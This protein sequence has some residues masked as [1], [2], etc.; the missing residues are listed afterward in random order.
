M[1]ISPCATCGYD[2]PLEAC[3][4]CS[5]RPEESI[6]GEPEANLGKRIGVGLAALP[7]G[8]G[9]LLVTG[10]VKRFLIP[11]VVLTSL[12]FAFLFFHAW[13]L[14]QEV[15]DAANLNDP[16][17]LYL[18]EGW[19]RDAAVWLIERPSMALREAAL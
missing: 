18:D 9:L 4:H 1:P 17:A 15:L 7:R 12:A 6:I 11:P 5:S 14:L 10:G 16:G 19:I 2:A 13:G 8:L 3:P